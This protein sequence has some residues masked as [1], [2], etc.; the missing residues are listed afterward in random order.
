MASTRRKW[1]D[2][3]SCCAPATHYLE[4]LDPRRPAPA[5][6]PLIIWA[7]EHDLGIFRRGWER[8]GGRVE[9]GLI[10]DYDGGADE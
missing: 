5:E 1:C 10:A 3:P 7:C 9:W 8:L 2:A 6:R 4:L